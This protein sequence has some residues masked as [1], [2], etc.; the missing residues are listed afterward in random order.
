M[1]P[2]RAGKPSREAVGLRLELTKDAAG[3]LQKTMSA[4]RS[5]FYGAVWYRLLLEEPL[6]NGFI[7]GMIALAR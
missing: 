7:S 1:A 6:D 2:K 5:C 3:H 4:I